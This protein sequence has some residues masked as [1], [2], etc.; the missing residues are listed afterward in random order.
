MVL[1][2]S[3]LVVGCSV[4]APVSLSGRDVLLGVVSVESEADRSATRKE[5]AV[6]GLWFGATGLGAGYKRQ[7]FLTLDEQCRV[8]FLI[9]NPDQLENA[10]ELVRT[11][12]NEP[13]R[14]IC[15]TDF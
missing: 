13:G 15:V 11:T 6:G 7:Q 8:V 4:A 14:D 9:E 2:V 5:A 10:I 3:S 12:L 1:L